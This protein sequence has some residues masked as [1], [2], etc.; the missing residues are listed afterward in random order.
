MLIAPEVVQTDTPRALFIGSSAARLAESCQPDGGDP[1][2]GRPQPLQRRPRHAEGVARQDVDLEHPLECR[3]VDPSVLQRVDREPLDRGRLTRNRDALEKE[4][5]EAAVAVVG[6]AAS[7]D[8]YSVSGERLLRHEE[9][10]GE[11]VGVL[12]ELRLNNPLGHPCPPV[13]W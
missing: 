7:Q 13:V 12:V 2:E 1:H 11:P 6:E 3:P 9:R 10:E 5:P 4:L 8:P